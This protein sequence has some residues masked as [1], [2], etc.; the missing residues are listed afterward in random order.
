MGILGYFT[1]H[2]TIANLLLVLMLAAGAMALPNMRA[3]FFP[4]VVVD[5]VSVSVSWDGA[6]AEDVDRGIVQLLEP[7]LLA[8][9]GVTDS[10]ANAREG[11]ASITL[12]FEPGRDMASAADDVQAAVDAVTGL[13]DGIDDPEV[14]QGAWR[15][16]VTDVIVTGPVGVDQ[17]ARITDEFVTRLFA[18]GVTRTTIRGVAAPE[19]VVEV[20]TANLLRHDVTMAQIASA[21]AGQ[22]QA[23]PAGDVTG[24]NARVRTGSARRDVAD[25]QDIVIRRN[26]DG[27]A[28]T[29]VDVGRVIS[30]G[31]DRDRA[32]FVEENP[33]MS[34]RV[35]RTAEGD[36][37]ALQRQVEEVAEA[38]M[39]DAPDGVT[40]ELIRTRTEAIAGRIN[41]LI[42]NA[43]MGLV[44]VIGLL[45]LFLNWRTAFWV[46]AGIPVALL[47]AIA[48]MWA[49]GLTINMISLF[50]LIITLGIVVDDAIVVGEHADFRARRLGETPYDAA[51]NAAR[52]MFLPV[53][54]A[55]LTTVIAFF[56]LVAIG[57]RFGDLIADIPFT[58]IVVL[59]A[60]L[61]ECF[62]ILPHHMAGALK[63]SSA[64]SWLDWPSRTVNRGFDWV[65]DT[66]FR[67]LIRL[68]IW[69]RY[70]VAAGA[71]V[72]LSSQAAL[73]MT[74]DV[75][76]RFFNAPERGSVTG[77][78]AMLDG[79]T[80]EDSLEQMRELQ[81][82]T[83]ALGED[84]E[85]RYGQN[86]LAY[87]LAEIGGNSGR[88]LPSAD[89]KDG[90]QLGA[91][92]IELIDAD[93]R[94]YS[95]FQFVG[96]LQEAARQLPLTEEISFRGWRSGPGGDALSV[97]FYGADSATLKAAAEAL[98]TAVSG[99]AEVSGVEDS[100]PYDKDELILELTP[101]GEALGFDIDA[102]GATLRDRLGGIEAATFPVGPRTGSIR[103]ELP[104][105]EIRADFLEGLR[106]KAPTGGDVALSDIVTVRVQ[107]GFATIRRENGVQVVT[108]SGDI[109]QDDA[110]RANEIRA[111]LADRILPEI[112]AV[113][114]VAYTLGGLAEQE[115]EF[116]TDATVGLVSCLLG[117]YLVLAWIFSS[118]TRPGV[119]MVVIPFGL[120]GAIWGH[121]WW[122][123]PLSMFSVVGLIGMT[124]II[125]ND[126]IVLITTVD[127]YS[128]DRALMPAIIDAVCDRL[129]PI[130][131]T[132]LTTVLG[133]T[134]LL[135]ES[136]SQ[137]QFLRPTVITLSYGL[138]FGM[139]L[140]LILVPAILA[141]GHDIGRATD[142]L[143][144]MLRLPGQRRGRGIGIL[145]LGLGSAIVAWGFATLGYV[146]ITGAG[147][148]PLAAMIPISGAAQAF[149]IF[150][151]GT[152]AL[153]LVTWI[154]AAVWIGRRKRAAP[155]V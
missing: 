84:Y 75:Q 59:I 33:A 77:N 136:S 29:V 86:P 30:E 118:W 45:F 8:V 69:A 68:A 129:R 54:S 58:V 38:V 109:T 149:A 104:Q 97:E 153:L 99:I 12:E 123:V 98:K 52:R 139:V 133:L 121:W 137:A 112:A 154:T 53:F 146:L 155:G 24:A 4:D 66:L 73:F 85:E 79:A 49:A 111:Q 89:D 23:D 1:R 48:L 22:T 110:A 55:T 82:A 94:P 74:G 128:R 39:Q 93:L 61:V 105:G 76:W 28:L 106:L 56:G 144:R 44:L 131:L 130:L 138:G 37:I 102:L 90:D 147:W 114:Q 34:V 13:P 91:I 31:V 125:I 40:V 36:A 108:V 17:L 65:K 134:P 70:P 32:Y 64:D 18:A 101:Q 41:L 148:P 47:S 140:V 5:E 150:A 126:S 43:L 135:Y 145:G 25:I 78:F 9:D 88:A 132:T 83:Y 6:G 50:A 19:I 42:D 81:R 92:S 72:L 124:G 115:R 152:A 119:I 51:E 71:I 87:V 15:D 141:M 20:P 100:L 103:V 116:L 142:A 143:R 120:I 14:R 113:H 107:S 60:S 63:N 26:A 2:H 127:E 57:G 7:A 11:S 10:V 96:E 27:S 46:A 80:R 3:Q 117:I 122:E 21:I 151:A 16:R 95:S 35:D 67:P 62:L